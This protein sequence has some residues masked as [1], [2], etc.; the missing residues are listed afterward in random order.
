MQWPCTKTDRWLCLQNEATSGCNH[1]TAKAVLANCASSPARPLRIQ[2]RDHVGALNAAALASSSSS[3]SNGGSD[4]SS[5]SSTN[6]A[7]KWCRQAA[8]K[9]HRLERHRIGQIP[10]LGQ[11]LSFGCTRAQESAAGPWFFPYKSQVTA[12]PWRPA[13]HP[14]CL[15]YNPETC[16][17]NQ[18]A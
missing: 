12:V 16:R 10:R 15:L 6:C 17:N 13:D 11:V 18:P 2:R 1:P 8:L 7:Y 3:S 9:C 5:S 4:S 14:P